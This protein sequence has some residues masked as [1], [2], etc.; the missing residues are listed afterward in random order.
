MVN[1]LPKFEALSVIAPLRY[2]ARMIFSQ[3]TNRY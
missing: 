3:S 1:I 2:K